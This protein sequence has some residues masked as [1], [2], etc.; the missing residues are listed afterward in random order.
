[1]KNAV[2]GLGILLL[3]ALLGWLLAFGA[4]PPCEAMQVEARKLADEKQDTFSKA[5]SAAFVNFKEGTVSP[6]ECIAMSI[7]MK[8]FGR[9]GVTVLVAGNAANSRPPK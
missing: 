3:G 2:I 1:M 5:I 8:A 7:R 4:T 6:V 9:S